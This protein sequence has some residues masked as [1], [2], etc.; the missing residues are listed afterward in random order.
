MEKIPKKTHTRVYK[1]N[2]Q[3]PKT[4]QPVFLSINIKTFQGTIRCCCAHAK[5]NNNHQPSPK[6]L[7]PL[8]LP[9][10][11]L[12]PP[13]MQQHQQKPQPS[14]QIDQQQPIPQLLYNVDHINNSESYDFVMLQC[15]YASNEYCNVLLEC[16]KLTSKLCEFNA[17]ANANSLLPIVDNQL[18]DTN[19]NANDILVGDESA[20]RIKPAVSIN[21][22]DAE[23]FN[24]C[25]CSLYAS[26]DNVLAEQESMIGSICPRC[27]NI[28]KQQPT[29]HRKTLISKRLTLSKDIIVNRVDTHFLSLKTALDTSTKRYEPYTPESIESH[30]P[31]PEVYCLEFEQSSGS[32]GTHTSNSDSCNA[33]GNANVN[34]GGVGI[35]SGG[36]AN[37]GIGGEKS[38]TKHIGTTDVPNDPF[39]LNNKV[40]STVRTL[41]THSNAVSACQLKSRLEILRKTSTDASGM[42]ISNHIAENRKRPIKH[43]FCFN[44]CCV[45][46]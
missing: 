19:A 33:D 17:I 38:E 30:S 9:P 20:H 43:G 4:M 45:I 11:H 15:P 10:S 34:A 22:T 40:H 8:K 18:S 37:A 32:S 28:I 23:N 46:L 39:D 16:N 6:P 7:A 41:Q 13:S 42:V 2:P 27:Q 35:G 29:E 12:L 36:T 5:I 14:L 31:L 21:V 1:I 24:V 26:C 25:M 3:Q 44:K